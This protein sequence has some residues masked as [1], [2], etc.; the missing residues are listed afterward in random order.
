MGLPEVMLLAVLPGKASLL[1]AE[2]HFFPCPHPRDI[3]RGRTGRELTD[4][5]LVYELP[6]TACP[7]HA[8]RGEEPPRRR[9]SP[10]GSDAVSMCGADASR[11]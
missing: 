2:D 1:Q 9:C 7:P 5:L 10:P 3:S 8:P 6:N 11:L 4:E